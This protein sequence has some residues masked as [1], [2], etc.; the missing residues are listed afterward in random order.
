MPAGKPEVVLAKN[1]D[2]EAASIEFMKE[3]NRAWENKNEAD[4]FAMLTDASEWDD[5][6][7][8]EPAKGKVGVQKYFKLFSTAFP[9]AKLATQNAW[10]IGDW[11]IEEGTYS[12]TNTGPLYGA[13]ATKR[14][15][16]IHEL[17]LVKLDK[18]DR[19]VKAITYGNDLEMT[20]QLTPPKTAPAK[21]AEKP[22]PKK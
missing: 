12:G 14:S 5:L 6:T 17:N 7:M 20:G 21:P 8:A 3:V 9:D 18:D 13:P 15:M 22:A 1:N 10:G 2:A 11:I 16:T 4:F 19:I